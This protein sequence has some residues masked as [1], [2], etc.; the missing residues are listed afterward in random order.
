[1]AVSKVE[2]KFDLEEAKTKLHEKQEKQRQELKELN[3]RKQEVAEGVNFL[4]D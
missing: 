2:R 4:H 1:M 3:T